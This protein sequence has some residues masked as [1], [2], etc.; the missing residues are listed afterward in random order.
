MKRNT[1]SLL[2]AALMCASAGI[3]QDTAVVEDAPAE[4][5]KVPPPVVTAMQRPVK[6]YVPPMIADGTAI[7]VLLTEDIRPKRAKPGDVV[8]LV[9]EHNFWHRNLLL[10]PAG[11]PVTAKVAEAHGAQVFSRGSKLT[12]EITSLKLLNGQELPLRGAPEYR[13]GN[14][15]PAG[16]ISGAFVDQAAHDGCILCEIVFVP[17]ALGSLVAPGT[18]EDAKAGTIAPLWV[19]GEFKLDLD[20]LRASQPVSTGPARLRIARGLLGSGSK[21]DLYC[22]GVPLARLTRNRK[23]EL[24]LAPGWYRF[25]IHPK[26]D[27]LEL[28]VAPNSHT[29]LIAVASRVL[30]AGRDDDTHA[31][32]EDR[33]LNMQ[34]LNPFA[35]PK[36][37][38]EY[39]EGAKLVDAAD[40]YQTTCEPLAI[41]AAANK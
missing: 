34:S 39:I 41:E 2:L 31:K 5:H 36:S 29:D 26:K 18:T 9:L 8:H 10:A 24:D 4:S 35:K 13:G 15:G 11:T 16:K 20:S 33:Q 40:V 22:N 1:V 3:A 17:I 32:K 25:A 23:L 6:S 12:L 30:I 38:L 7:S 37:E 27:F 21:G 19:N 28:W 14:V